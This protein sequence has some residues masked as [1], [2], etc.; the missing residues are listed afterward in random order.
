[1]SAELVI[2]IVSLCASIAIGVLTVLANIR[3]SKISHLEAVKKYEKNITN[4]E[5]QF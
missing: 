3:I 1:M 4:F 5:L 2:S